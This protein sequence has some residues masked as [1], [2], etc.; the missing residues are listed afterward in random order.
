MANWAVLWILVFLVIYTQ[1]SRYVETRKLRNSAMK[2]LEVAVGEDESGAWLLHYK[3][4]LEKY[5]TGIP[6]DLAAEL[7]CTRDELSFYVAVMREIVELRSG[8]AG[9]MKIHKSK[10]WLDTP[11]HIA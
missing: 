11:T 9:S 10:H 2:L 1:H 3:L 8:G 4:I 7:K 5:D 6:N